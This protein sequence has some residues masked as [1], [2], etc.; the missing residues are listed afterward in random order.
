MDLI[1]RAQE[2]S[3]MYLIHTDVG[4]PLHTITAIRGN[5]IIRDPP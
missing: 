1:S 5:S 4:I 3:A 2:F